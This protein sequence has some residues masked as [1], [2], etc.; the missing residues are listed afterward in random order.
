MCYITKWHCGSKMCYQWGICV[1]NVLP[2][3]KISLTI[4]LKK[5]VYFA[6]YKHI[7]LPLNATIL[8]PY[9][10][11]TDPMRVTKSKIWCEGTLITEFPHIVFC[12]FEKQKQRKRLHISV[13]LYLESPCTTAVYQWKRRH[14][15]V[16]PTIII[17]VTSY[18]QQRY[19]LLLPSLPA[20]IIAVN[21]FVFACIPTDYNPNGLWHTFQKSSNWGNQACCLFP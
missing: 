4:V 15:F 9:C 21:G 18:H 16:K 10:V 8:I 19:Q 6:D 12:I 17:I 2:L 5:V 14:I 1:T 3:D 11:T 13:L 20:I 7:T